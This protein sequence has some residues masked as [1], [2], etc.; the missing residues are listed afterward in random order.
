MWDC[1]SE[2]ANYHKHMKK[3]FFKNSSAAILVFSIL[4]EK[5]KEEVAM[6]ISEAY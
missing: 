6:W 3:A 2:H 1:G 4:N 5:W